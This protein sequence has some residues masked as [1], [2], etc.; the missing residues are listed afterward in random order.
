MF[1]GLYTQLMLVRYNPHNPKICLVMWLL[2]LFPCWICWILILKWF[3]WGIHDHYCWL[4]H[5]FCTDSPL[6]P[7]VLVSIPI[8]SIY[9]VNIS[10]FGW[11]EAHVCGT[12]CN[13]RCGPAVNHRWGPSSPV[14]LWRRRRCEGGSEWMF[15]WIFG[16][17][18]YQTII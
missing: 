17:E 15:W 14:P 4:N 13:H 6:C 10:Y 11:G 16:W 9:L 3:W 1:V 8:I 2:V 7:I 5:D 12:Y 18:Y